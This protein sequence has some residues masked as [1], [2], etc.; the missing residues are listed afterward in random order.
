VVD[1]PAFLTAFL[2]AWNDHD[3]HRIVEL[4]ARGAT[5]A[6]PALP[7]AIHGRAALKRYYKQQWT[8]IPNARLEC[9]AAA[10]EKETVAW[11]WRY[12]GARNSI[13]FE[14]IGASHFVLSSGAIAVDRAVWN[15]DLL[16]PPTEA[17][18][19]IQ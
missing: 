19:D 16:P 6:D 9:L 12:S 15:P 18:P 13:D 14:I 1:Q 4:Y 3:V 17:P 2:R 5:M 11:L 8:M 10:E 7:T